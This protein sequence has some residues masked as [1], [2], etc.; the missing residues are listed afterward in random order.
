[1]IE[2]LLKDREKIKQIALHNHKYAKEHFIA[3]K[4]AKGIEGILST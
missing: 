2:P 3:S 4:V 1:M